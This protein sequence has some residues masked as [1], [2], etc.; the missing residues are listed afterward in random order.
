MRATNQGSDPH[1]KTNNI[2]QRVLKQN[3]FFFPDSSHSSCCFSDLPIYNRNQST[4]VFK[5]LF[6]HVFTFTSWKTTSYTVIPIRQVLG[7][8]Y[9]FFLDSV[10]TFHHF[11]LWINTSSLSVDGILPYN[12]FPVFQMAN[13]TKCAFT[14]FQISAPIPRST[15]IV[16][17]CCEKTIYLSTSAGH[18][19]CIYRQLIGMSYIALTR[20]VQIYRNI[21]DPLGRLGS[22]LFWYIVF[23]LATCNTLH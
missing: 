11:H 2:F 6:S 8:N 16:G 7:Q 22:W 1:S 23:Q 17:K 9:F 12:F 15:F 19:L 14:D 5:P 10:H 18:L 21:S 4:A 20:Q 13:H 3:H